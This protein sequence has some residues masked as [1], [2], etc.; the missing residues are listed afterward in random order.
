MTATILAALLAIAAQAGTPPP[1]TVLRTIAKGDQSFIDDA[2]QAVARTS[3]EWQALWR[4]HDPERRPPAVDFTKEMVVG[5]F[6]GS[7]PTAGWV[8]EIVSAAPEG[9]ALVV[10]YREQA[11]PSGGVTAQVITSYYHIVALPRTSAP[12]RFEKL[13]TE[14]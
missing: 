14:K 3:A 12:V 10:R 13:K 4:Q 6:L 8:L 9:D 7:R 1:G 5:V 2:K 11:P